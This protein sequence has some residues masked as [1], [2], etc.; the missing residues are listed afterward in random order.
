MWD[1][2]GG[3]AGKGIS[4]VENL[5][6]GALVVGEVNAVRQFCFAMEIRGWQASY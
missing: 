5:G 4:K 3:G 1:W 6:A 2:E